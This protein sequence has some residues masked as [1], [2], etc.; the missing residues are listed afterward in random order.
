MEASVRDAA[1]DT[2][3]RRKPREHRHDE[4]SDVGGSGMIGTIDMRLDVV[5]LPVA[6]AKRSYLGL[7]WRLDADIV[8][9]DEFPAVQVTP[10]RS[11]CSIAFGKG[12]TSDSARIDPAFAARRVG[13]S[14]ARADLA[15][16]G[17]AV[18]EVSISTA[19]RYLGR[20]AGT[21]LCHVRRVQRSRRQRMATEGDH[22]QASGWPLGDLSTH[23]GALRQRGAPRQR[24]C[25]LPRPTR[26]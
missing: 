17:V 1:Q 22:N 25:R 18:G 4:R 19:G 9:G 20:P 21:V 16:R 11:A 24:C 3:T 10:P 23:A 8:S 13:H 12:V 15:D 2:T 7:G 14:A 6:R 5:T 26:K